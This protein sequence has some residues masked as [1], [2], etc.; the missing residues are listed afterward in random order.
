MGRIIMTSSGAANN[1][2]TSWGAYGSS[3][4]ALNHLALTLAKEEPDIITVAVRPG[5]V[6]TKMQEDIRGKLGKNMDEDDA[7]KFIG[8]FEDDM[9]L[10][11]AQPG[12]VM[13]KLAVGA[14]KDLSGTFVQWND[15]R[16]KDYQS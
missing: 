10:K 11:P 9:L 3:K 4:A 7:K 16:L 14:N 13:A 8:A 12:S 5:M 6:A 2:Y 1:A 15:E